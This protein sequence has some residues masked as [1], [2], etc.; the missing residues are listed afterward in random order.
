MLPRTVMI[1]AG[2]TGGHVYPGL[3]VADYLRQHDVSIIWLGT[4][5]GLE[6]RVV[7]GQGY[8]FITIQVSGLRGKGLLKLITAPFMV[9]KA[10]L[11]SLSVLRQ[12]KPDVVLGMGGF[13]SGPG[14]IAAWL[15]RIP[16]FIHE[17][18]SIP[19]TT[20]RILALFAKVV[21]EG[22][23]GTF[24]PGNRILTTGNPVRSEMFNV[25]DPVSRLSGSPD[26]C[27]RLLVIGGS[28]G[29][30]VL[31][32]VLPETIQ[33][34]EGKVDI[35]IW[36]QVGDRN[37]AEAKSDYAKVNQSYR[38]RIEPFIE[39]MAEAYSWADLVLCRAGALTIAELCAVGIASILVPFPYATD[40]HQKKNAGYLSDNG[41][42]V[43]IDEGDLQASIL[44][45]LLTEISGA[46]NRIFEMAIAARKLA[47]PGATRAVADVCMGVTYG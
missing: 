43:L 24:K 7:P 13:V 9:L 39:D 44:A 10:I 5:T 25:Q 11:Q 4:A 12:A 41:A 19:G 31:N 23:P 8:R 30:R 33:Q 1:I 17:Q 21:M 38:I 47:R 3:A 34:L 46:R 36:H 2:G 45:K 15:S 35:E 6:A 14:G 18:N 40:N 28:Q 20:N 26:R 27:M 32:K 37:L 42:A 22:F 16:L 29:A